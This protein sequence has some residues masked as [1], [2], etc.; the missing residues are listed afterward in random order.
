MEGHS[1]NMKNKTNLKILSQIVSNLVQNMQQNEY[2]PII[3][4]TDN[5]N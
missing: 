4:Y 2:G 3:I 5:I 1:K